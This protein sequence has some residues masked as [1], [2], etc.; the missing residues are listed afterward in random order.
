LERDELKSA[1]EA[2]LFASEKPL[3]IEQMKEAFMDA[4]TEAEIRGILDELRKEY[5]AQNRGFRLLEI[6]GGYQIVTDPRFSEHLKRFYQS[7][8]KKKL[9][10][11]T[12]ETLSVVAYKQPVTRADIEFIRGVSVDGAVRTLLEKGLVKIVGRK[13]VPGRP[14]LYGTTKEFLDHFGLNTIKEL[15]ALS[16]FSEKDIDPS[17]LPPEMKRDIEEAKADAELEP[18]PAE[19]LSDDYGNQKPVG[20]ANE[21]GDETSAR[22]EEKEESKESL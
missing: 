16:E 6:A 7:R 20:C 8:L 11:A 13:E 4:P 10:Q 15:P 21:P 5:E 18:T 14:M 12:L 17:L 3:I 22:R 19:T 2:L 9:S 1:F